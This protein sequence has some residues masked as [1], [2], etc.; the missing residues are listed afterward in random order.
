MD[1][2][3]GEVDVAFIWGPIAGYFSQQ[4]DESLLVTP[5]LKEDNR[6]RMNYRVSMAVRFNETDWK[7][8]VNATLAA[9]QPQV[10]EILHEYGVPLLNDRG[11]WLPAP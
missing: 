7:H 3:S 11:E 10:D 1:V 5:L 4:I 2:A 8:T 9:I 6:V